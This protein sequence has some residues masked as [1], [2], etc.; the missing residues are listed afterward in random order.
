MKKIRI[1]GI[2]PGFGRTGWGVIEGRRDQWEMV[3]YGCIETEVG[4]PFVERLL[5]LNDEL[6]NYNIK[7]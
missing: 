7:D 1:L 3:D 2:D 5:E 4:K 6:K